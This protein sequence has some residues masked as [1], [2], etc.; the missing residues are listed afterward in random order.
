MRRLGGVLLVLLVLLG[1][2]TACGSSGGGTTVPAAA[3]ATAPPSPTAAPRTPT[4][5]PAPTRSPI[6]TPTATRPRPTPT[7]TVVP[8][9]APTP[10]TARAAVVGTATEASGRCSAGLP[11]GFTPSGAGDDTWLSA[12]RLIAIQ[13]AAPAPT[14]PISLDGATDAA[15]VGLRATIPDAREQGRTKAVGSRR[16]A[17]TGSSDGK[18]RW[19]TIAVRAFGLDFCQVTVIATIGTTRF[20][21]PLIEATAGSLSARNP[22]PAPVGYLALGDSYAAG[23]GASDPPTRGYVPLFADT[24]LGPTGQPLA[25]RNLGIPGATSADLLGDWAARGADGTG[26]LAGAVRTLGAGGITVVTLDIGGNDILRLLK[27]GE[28]CAGA[29]IDGDPC[30]A[31]MREQLRAVSAVNIPPIVAALV[32]AAVPGTQLLVLTYPNPFSTGQGGITAARTDLAMGELNAIIG[33]TVRDNTARA[34]T[35]GVTLTLVDLA[36][37]FAGRGGT[38]T[39]IRDTPPDI[40][41]TDA[42]HAAIADLLKEARTSR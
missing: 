19:G 23:V 29:A 24:L 31:A 11:V 3:P 36:P 35:R 39:H 15:L 26:P 34:A 8:T 18:A 20:L 21:D 17:F 41:P 14:A 16:V 40:H 38:L 4:A 5:R 28:A 37:T 7:A 10:T 25:A 9:V 42:G 30:L 22:R 12:D 32:E 33:G 6:P 13:L 27:P 1:I 2:L